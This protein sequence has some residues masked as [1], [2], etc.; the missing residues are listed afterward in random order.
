MAIFKPYLMKSA[1][2]GKTWTSISNN[3]PARGS[4]YCVTEDYKNKNLLFCGTSLVFYFSTADKE[5]IGWR[6][7]AAYLNL[8][9]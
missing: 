1:D 5:K 4:V 6:F 7:Q 8:F 2:E 9:A 3:L